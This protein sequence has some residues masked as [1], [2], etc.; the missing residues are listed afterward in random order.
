MRVVNFNEI[1]LEYVQ[2]NNLTESAKRL[3]IHAQNQYPN[4]DVMVDDLL[5]VIDAEAMID[6]IQN[7]LAWTDK[8]LQNWLSLEENHP[9]QARIELPQEDSALIELLLDVGNFLRLQYLDEK[10]THHQQQL[11]MWYEFTNTYLFQPHN[12]TF[13][14]FSHFWFCN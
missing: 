5:K 6:L 3:T 1:N 9:Y 7:G 12:F 11:R 13:V 8:E 10:T 4:F 14:D 2:P